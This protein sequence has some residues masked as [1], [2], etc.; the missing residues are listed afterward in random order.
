MARSRARARLNWVSQ[1]QRWGRCRVRRRAERGDSSGEGEEPPPEGLGGHHL[2]AQTGPRCPTGQVMRHHLYRQPGG[3]GGETARRHVVQ[4]HAVLEVSNGVLDLGVTAMIS[5]QLQRL[6]VPV[7]DEA[8]IAVGGEEGELGTGRRL[9]PPDNEPH[10]RGVRL[11]LERGVSRLGNIGGAVHPVGN[12]SPVLLR[13]RLDQV[14]Q[15]FVLADGD[16][17]AHVQLA[18]DG[19][20][21]MGVEAAVGPHRE[22]SCSPSMAHPPHRLTEEVGGAAG[23]VGAALA[24]P[25]HQHVA[26]A[27]GNGQQRVIPSRAGV[28]VVARSLLGQ[29]IGLADGRVQVDGQERVAGSGPSGPGPGQQLP[30]HAVELT[31]MPPAKA[32]QEGAQGGWRLDHAA[33]NT[34]RPTGAQRIG[35]VDAVAASQGGGDQRQHLVPRVRP[36]RRAAEVKVM[37][38]EF[39]QAQVLGEGHREQQP[40]IGHQAVV[41]KRDLDAIG[42][43]AW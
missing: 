41:V 29:S 33:E 36:S 27:G 37:V 43:V 40:S 38:D 24:Q 23:G 7:G 5:L 16:G 15:A 42:M 4:P 20:H 3:V 10:R 13:Y 1:G 19:Y 14:P 35:V 32:A 12:G 9:H 28:A 17:E 21:A 31:D 26:G 11:G 18:A 39:G 34:D 6:P 22:L 30:A 25:G 8:V 2:L